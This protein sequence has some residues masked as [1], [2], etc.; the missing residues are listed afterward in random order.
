MLAGLALTAIT[1]I[2]AFQSFMGMTMLSGAEFAIAI[3]CAIAIIPF[4][5][6]QKFVEW[7]VRKRKNKRIENYQT[8]QNLE[9]EEQN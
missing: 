6:A 1:F 9:T 4:V 5:E 8:E 7:Y 3:G 2:P